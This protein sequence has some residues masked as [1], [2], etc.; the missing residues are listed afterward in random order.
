MTSVPFLESTG[1]LQ[2]PA[3]FRN[4]KMGSTDK[5][6]QFI[7]KPDI[8]P[9]AFAASGTDNVS[10][11]T[12]VGSVT[13][14]GAIEMRNTYAQGFCWDRIASMTPFDIVGTSGRGTHWHGH[15]GHLWLWKREL[16]QL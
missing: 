7:V 4:S 16:S 10:N 5:G 15:S 11:F 13:D 12:L 1:L 6:I 9:F 3:E 2:L 14:T 8:S